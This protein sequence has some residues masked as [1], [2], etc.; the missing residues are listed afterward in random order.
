[1]INKFFKQAKK[2]PVTLTVSLQEEQ[3]D[4]MK[5]ES[6]SKRS[7][8][9]NNENKIIVTS[10]C[11]ICDKVIKYPR[12]G[13]GALIEKAGNDVS[14]SSF[15]QT[16]FN[17]GGLCFRCNLEF[18]Q[19]HTRITINILSADEVIEIL[20]RSLPDDQNRHDLENE[21]LNKGLFDHMQQLKAVCPHCG[22]ELN[23]WR[24]AF[25]D[26]M[27]P[28]NVFWGEFYKLSVELL[29]S[30]PIFKNLTLLL[31]NMRSVGIDSSE[32]TAVEDIVQ[33]AHLNWQQVVLIRGGQSLMTQNKLEDALNTFSEAFSVKGDFNQ[34]ALQFL[35][36]IYAALAAR[37]N[38]QADQGF[39][40]GDFK[41]ALNFLERAYAYV[42]KA[43]PSN[44]DQA[45]A[46]N[47]RVRLAKNGIAYQNAFSANDFLQEI[48]LIDESEEITREILQRVQ[49]DAT[50]AL[51][52]SV[53]TLNQN[54]IC[55]IN[56][57]LSQASEA[58]KSKDYQRALHLDDIAID[59]IEHLKTKVWETLEDYQNNLLRVESARNNVKKGQ[60]DDLRHRGI[61]AWQK[62]DY[63][64]A[65]QLLEDGVK[66]LEPFSNEP[67]MDEILKNAK[68]FWIGSLL[69]LAQDAIQ[70]E[71][72]FRAGEY[73]ERAFKIVN[74][75][76]TDSEMVPIYQQILGERGLM[77]FGMHDYE[78][79]LNEM[80]KLSELDPTNDGAFYNIACALSR[81]GR[82]DEVWQPLRQSFELE[83]AKGL[84][85]RVEAAQTDPDLASI[86]GHS[87]F[88]SLLN[89]YLK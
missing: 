80:Q 76:E 36:R 49:P 77:Y 29:D 25:S 24:L 11:G 13:G 50:Q 14:L 69:H 84:T 12:G 82:V 19:N 23:N 61:E 64:T 59:I 58:L 45:D 72:F 32:I 8:E 16:M 30:E 60:S 35:N 39:S 51:S 46:I 79:A 62:K 6:V 9:K 44:T 78:A 48:F 34:V 54:R 22:M 47:R 88:K 75:Y 31:D 17:P 3:K 33:R 38:Q 40:A 70:K 21:A 65:A 66:I 5:I 4:K 73:Y 63:A 83:R 43:Q 74:P 86:R 7:F 27:Q 10:R 20:S 68:K 55:V 67:K 89:E 85:V 18:C 87:Q 81:L 71:D 56:R 57:C 1:M 28:I 37:Y 42:S 26:L 15:R 53:V 41:V 52:Q 2:S